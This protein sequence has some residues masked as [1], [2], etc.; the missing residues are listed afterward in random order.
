M[1]RNHTDSK[2]INFFL[3]PCIYVANGIE[4]Q[5]IAVELAG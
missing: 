5:S 1:I 3:T 4:I 2:V